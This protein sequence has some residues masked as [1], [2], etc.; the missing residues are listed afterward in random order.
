[1]VGMKKQ[2]DH[3]ESTKIERL[4]TKQK[5]KQ[6]ILDYDYK[7]YRFSF[8]FQTYVGDILIAVNPFRDIGIYD[9]EV[10][11]KTLTF[12]NYLSSF[13]IICCVFSLFTNKN[14]Y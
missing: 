1:M 14:V 12:L 5:Q 8:S 4:K 9:D 10:S 7:D 6:P 3:A 13:P 2:N 11:N